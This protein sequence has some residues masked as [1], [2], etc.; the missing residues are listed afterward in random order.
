MKTLNFLS[1]SVLMAFFVFA[2]VSCD[3]LVPKGT[4]ADF[5]SFTFPGIE[6]QAAIAPGAT[7]GTITAKA[8]AAT[9][10]S[11]IVPFFTIS[12]GAKA[13][14]GSTEQKSGTTNPGFS[15]TSPAVV[16]YSVISEDAKTNKTW[17]VT[18]TKD[19]SNPSTEKDADFL[20]F[21]FEGIAGA[22]TI[23]KSA[24]TITAQAG[25][26]VNL[27]AIKPVFSLSTGATAKVGAEAQVSNVTV[28][29]FTNPVVYAVTSG[30][31]SANRNWTVTITKGGGG[32]STDLTE[33]TNAMINQSNAVLQPGIYIVKTNLT[34]NSANNLTIQPGVEIRFEK[35][36]SFA[37]DGKAILKAIGT[38]T[39][40][41][42]F[43]SAIVDNK[44]PGDWRG[45]VFIDSPNSEFEWC[46]FEYGSG[47]ES[48]SNNG[49]LNIRACK[50]AVNYC[51]FQY[52]LN[53][54]IYLDNAA[55]GFSSFEQNRIKNCG[56][57][58]NN[59]YPIRAEGGIMTV[60]G[61]GEGNGIETSKG[62]SINGGSVDNTV[63]L[64]SFVPYIIT[65][66]ITVKASSTLTLEAGTELMFG[67]QR[68]IQVD[69][70]GKLIAIGD[71]TNQI[72]FTG[73]NPTKTAGDWYG[74]IIMNN[75]TGSEFEHC[76]FENGSG[77]DSWSNT[78]FLNIR[79]GAKIS[80]KNCTFRDGK[81]SGIYLDGAGSGFAT[82]DNNTII[83]CGES[84]NNH[85][86]MKAEGGVLTLS[87]IGVGNSITS[88]SSVATKGIGINGGTVT[89]DM[90]LQSFVPYV[91]YTN[92]IAINDSY[93]LTLEAGTVLKFGIGR[94][95][96]VRKGGKLIAVGN[97]SNKITFTS[98]NP[99][100]NPGDWYGIFIM[101]DGTGSVFEH[102]IFEY[103]SGNSGWSNTGLLN[104]RNGAKT[105]VKNC[106]FREA[107]YS[108]IYL[109]GADSGFTVFDNNTITN[110]GENETDHYP[111]K[112][113]GGIMAL[114]GIMYSTTDNVITTSKG[115]GIRGGTVNRAMKLKR[116]VYFV[117]TNDISV[118]SNVTEAI[119]TIEP[120]AILKFGSNLSFTVGAGG[121][122]IAQGGAA[123]ADKIQFVGRVA[124]PGYWYGVH[125][126][127][128]SV[129]SGNIMNNCIVS[130]GGFGNSWT[131]KGNINCVETLA[132]RVTIQNCRITH[133]LRNGIFLYRA[134]T[135][136]MS[137][138]VFQN[139]EGSDVLTEN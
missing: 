10:L 83:G 128:N 72:T 85:Y 133:S 2:I 54:G 107:K 118:T 100:Q 26:A 87:G 78:G 125:F 138:N 86:P 17:T 7:S 41:I 24:G 11:D 62:I 1:I 70:G 121:R 55:G 127:G 32:G 27:A 80:V 56:E 6:G 39:Q 129:L 45:F 21:T 67:L 82:F 90:T 112:A 120:G 63:L 101:N 69:Q 117:Y 81:Y 105:S 139:I 42:L 38:Q 96:E 64:R 104:L 91:I 52:A 97:A 89:A 134:G 60:Q 111:I 88:G 16:T 44:Q 126:R 93:T 130:H 29:N 119:L 98:S 36:R 31:G 66:N 136:T 61:I 15:A 57:T 131:S 103:G 12:Q 46:I 40:P 35:D 4:E 92:Y 109:D 58:Q 71:A 3:D 84:Q 115:I 94:S 53:S 99:T 19:S 68:S 132:N 8:S 5:E 114:E 47:G 75:G 102:C 20:S 59:Q 43:T 77:G 106:T 50:V 49:L 95:I 28:N 51:I 22:A 116:Y 137:G 123:E 74:I 48:W 9:V 73:N 34:L 108:G 37:V 76:I 124:D 33:L 65:G 18:I 79:N 30:D 23:N 122:L 25:D 14:V 135:V 113:D 110:C 13:L